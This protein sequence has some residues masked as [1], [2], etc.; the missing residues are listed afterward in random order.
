MSKLPNV[1]ADEA[2]AVFEKLGFELARV[3]GSH[4]ILKKPGH[5]TLVSVPQ[6]GKTSLKRGTLRH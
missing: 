1:T 5:P 3:H 6:H 2:I 4:H